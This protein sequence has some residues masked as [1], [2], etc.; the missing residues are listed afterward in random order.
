MIAASSYEAVKPRLILDLIDY[1]DKAGLEW[2]SQDNGLSGSGQSICSQVRGRHMIHLL[3]PL[4][5]GRTEHI[6]MSSKALA[7]GKNLSAASSSQ[8]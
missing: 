6:D 2:Q 5:S 1:P 8:L 3:L 4:V 7:C